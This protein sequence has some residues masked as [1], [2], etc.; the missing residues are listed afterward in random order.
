MGTKLVV[1]GN[2]P[3]DKLKSIIS[4]STNN[5]QI[6]NHIK[7]HNDIFD[8]LRSRLPNSPS[9]LNKSPMELLYLYQEDIKVP[10]C[11]CGKERKY[12]CQGY[13][14]TCTGKKCINIKREKSKKEF[15]LK[16]YGV[17]FVTQL[18]TMKENSKKTL[19][20]RYGVDNITKSKEVIKERKERNLLKWGV[21]DPIVLPKFR[22]QDIMNKIHYKK[23]S[24]RLPEGYEYH[25]HDVSDNGDIEQ[26]YYIVSCPKGHTFSISKYVLSLKLK[27]HRSYSKEICN[28]CNEYIGS[29]V[30]QEVYNYIKS[31]YPNDISRSNRKLISPFEIDMV[32][33]DIKLGIEFNGDYWH[34]TNIVEDQFYHLNKL[35]M[36]LA[37]GYKLLQIKENDWY[38]NKELIELKLK[39]VIL[40]EVPIIRSN[41]IEMDLS[42]YDDRFKSYGNWEM[43]ERKMPRIISVGQ[44]EQWD[45]G[46][47]LYRILN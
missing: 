20:E 27:G 17:E 21:E 16:N 34:S 26:N 29:M 25:G 32:L 11:I 41:V 19:M 35:N 8:F 47:E 18:D 15:C 14:P 42:W 46:K 38:N 22:R 30:E 13:R 39:S 43:I 6:T 28:Q 40:N 4:Q 5:N 37:K 44:Y 23:I 7:K 45:S 2:T 31:I 1:Y 3:E 9:I 10:L 24:D 33:T 36:C 12:H